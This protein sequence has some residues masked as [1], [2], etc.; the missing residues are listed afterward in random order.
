MSHYEAV[1]ALLRR[2][3]LR[4]VTLLKMM[5]SY[6]DKIDS[7]LVEQEEQWGVLLLMSASTFAYDHRTYPEADAVVLMDYSSPEV[8]PAVLELIPRD[9]NLV[10]KLQK[11]EYRQALDPYITLQKVRSVFSYSTADVQSF[12]PDE[13]CIVC[14][15]LDERLLPLWAANDYSPAEL[16]KCFQEGAFSVSLFEG[17]VPLSTCLVFPNGERIWEI[18]AVHTTAHV[19]RSGLAHRVVRTAL[20]HTLRQGYIPRYQVM[21]ENLA[22]IRLAESLGLHLR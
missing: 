3:P 17:E 15:S 7:Y 8:F 12:T 6:H 11:D 14:D 1:M 16:R 9:N 13:T 22:S 20:H 19:R 5:T 18:G 21:E 2:N 4:N 10:F